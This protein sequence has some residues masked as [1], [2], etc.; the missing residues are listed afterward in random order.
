[1]LLLLHLDEGELEVLWDLGQVLQEGGRGGEGGREGG[2]KG[3]VSL[4]GKEEMGR[5]RSEGTS[6]TQ[7]HALIT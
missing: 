4:W 3:E 5:Q 6:C 2:R 7:I 1:M